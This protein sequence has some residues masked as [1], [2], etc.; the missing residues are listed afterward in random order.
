MVIAILT[1]FPQLQDV[2]P[3]DDCDL[4]DSTLS[5]KELDFSQRTGWPLVQ[6]LSPTRQ[7]GGLDH[8]VPVICIVGCKQWK[9][10]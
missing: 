1:F 10:L 4:S 9:T 5:T 7:Q 2:L 6:M 3:D 8:I